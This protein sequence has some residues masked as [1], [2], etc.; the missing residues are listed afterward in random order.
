MF[1]II[2][3][4]AYAFQCVLL[5]G[6]LALF[7]LDPG[8]GGV[9]FAAEC[10][11]ILCGLALEW[12]LALSP[13]ARL[14]PARLG[15]WEVTLG[16]FLLLVWLVVICGLVG[17]FGVNVW[18]KIHPLNKAQLAIV[19]TLA[20]QLSLLLGMLVHRLGFSRRSTPLPFAFA[21][22]A[23]SGL[24][25]FLVALPVVT[26][27]GL[28]WQALLALCGIKPEIQEA[29]DLLRFTDSV[30]LR[31]LLLFVAVVV[32]PV[33]EE[34][35]FRAGLFRFLRTRWPRWAALLLPAVLFALLHLNLG[36]FVPL[37][38]L[39]LVFSL[40]YE[41]TGNVGTTIVAHALFNLNASLLV[42]A[43]VN[44]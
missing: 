42:L 37:V 4:A 24:A 44:L 7:G 14:Q 26:V 34:L 36:S 11:L 38:A 8:P 1:G 31:G 5:I 20:F 12:K 3:Y 19:A 10:V 23:G 13:A 27:V 43:G 29:I 16:E 6:G 15:A 9:V 17:Q 39:A 40:A 41:R 35:I 28:I 25:T 21:G 32:A 30:W 33:T 2:L 22:A 18:Q